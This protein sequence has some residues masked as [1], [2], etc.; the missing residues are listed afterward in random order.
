M[1]VDENWE[2]II[3]RT[4]RENDLLTTRFA[5]PHD[6]WFHTRIFRGTH[7]ILRNLDKKEL[8]ENLK[9]ICSRLAAYFSKAKKSSNVP[10]DYTQIRFVRKP[11]GSPT[12]YVVYTNQKTLFVDP[13]SMREASVIIRSLK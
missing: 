6:W 8:P 5:K 10:V 7:I 4:S 2:I 3:G 13:L 12:G 11:K 1:K 9:I